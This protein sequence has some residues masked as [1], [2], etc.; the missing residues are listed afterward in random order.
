MAWL[1]RRTPAW[2]WSARQG[3]WETARG[4]KAL[5]ALAPPL[6]QRLRPR[7]RQEPHHAA[8]QKD[9]KGLKKPCLPLALHFDV[10]PEA[11]LHLPSS[12]LFASRRTPAGRQSFVASN[13]LPRLA[14]AT[15]YDPKG[16]A[17][18]QLARQSLPSPKKKRSSKHLLHHAR[19]RVDRITKEPE[20]EVSSHFICFRHLL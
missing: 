10:V 3:A 6:R 7:A 19:S 18:L 8:W 5:A 1:P 13:G 15:V 17:K 20:P 9:S 16:L 2:P 14:K 11:I 12:L 4:R